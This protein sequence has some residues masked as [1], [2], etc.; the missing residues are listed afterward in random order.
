MDHCI[1]LCIVCHAGK[2]HADY[3]PD[4]YNENM[5]RVSS[6]QTARVELED[7]GERKLDM[8]TDC[9]VD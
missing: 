9:D 4:L 1:L 2:H 3:V 8:A 6:D 5:V 7:C